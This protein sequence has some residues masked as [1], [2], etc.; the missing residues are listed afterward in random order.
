VT[1]APRTCSGARKRANPPPY[2][3]ASACS[4]PSPR[5][6]RSRC[7]AVLGRQQDVR[8]LQIPVHDARLVHRDQTFGERRP[9][10]GDLGAGS[11]PFSATL[12]CSEGPGTYCVAN[13]GR[14]ASRSAA[15]SRAYSRRGCAG[16]RTL[17]GEPRANSWSSAK[18]GPDHLERHALTAL[19]RA[20]VHHAMRPRP[21]AGAAGTRRRPA[22]PP[23]RSRIIAMSVR[24]L[25]PWWG[26][27]PLR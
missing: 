6:S 13:H 16:P 1:A 15:T 2:R 23:R 24:P 10:R 20:Q 7:S 5:R 21:A 19:V 3:R 8:R 25:P 18:F 14:S 26:R 12:S 4:R 17:A 11:T 9:D 22:D 27:A